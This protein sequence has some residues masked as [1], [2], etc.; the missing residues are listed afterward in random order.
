[1]KSSY[2]EEKPKPKTHP[3]LFP[4]AGHPRRSMLYRKLP[5]DTPEVP[6]GIY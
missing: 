1:M 5:F 6:P 3:F 2:V 4:I